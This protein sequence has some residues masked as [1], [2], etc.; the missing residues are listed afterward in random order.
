[1][2]VLV[3][4]E[5]GVQYS[6]GNVDVMVSM[7]RLTRLKWVARFRMYLEKTPTSSLVQMS[8]ITKLDFDGR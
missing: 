1:V 2:R 6:F 3:A 8:V 4:G 5:V 7:I